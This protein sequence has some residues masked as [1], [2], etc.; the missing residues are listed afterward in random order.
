M[1]LL[2]CSRW[3]PRSSVVLSREHGS[4]VRHDPETRITETDRPLYRNGCLTINKSD[5]R[6]SNHE[7]IHLCNV[8]VGST[9]RRI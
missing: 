4:S 5:A 9:P 8:T 1:G 6:A 3:C 7:S 2:Q